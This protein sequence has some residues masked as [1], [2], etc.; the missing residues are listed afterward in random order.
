MGTRQ[1][2]GA[3][4]ALGLA[5]S[6]IRE[7]IRRAGVHTI[8][9]IDPRR[10][11][12]LEPDGYSRRRRLEAHIAAEFLEAVERC[13]IMRDVDLFARIGRASNEAAD[14]LKPL[15]PVM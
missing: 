7:L 4:R 15:L 12:P 2:W 3:G 5:E 9:A 1:A 14:A 10:A 11:G 13:G 8:R 6:D